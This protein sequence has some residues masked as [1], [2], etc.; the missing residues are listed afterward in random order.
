[1]V[2]LFRFEPQIKTE[3]RVNSRWLRFPAMNLSQMHRSVTRKIA[4][5]S[6][7]REVWGQAVALRRYHPFF[8]NE[9]VC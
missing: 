3:G 5:G 9:A 2:A 8:L 6:Y 1:M 7:I 4:G